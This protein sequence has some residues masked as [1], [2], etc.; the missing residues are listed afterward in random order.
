M[1]DYEF[2]THSSFCEQNL[3]DSND[4]LDEI[5]TRE[6]ENQENGNF[7]LNFLTEFRRILV[8]GYIRFL[9]L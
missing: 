5:I 7:D 4:I 6:K 9:R 8:L 2:V 1:S 3:S